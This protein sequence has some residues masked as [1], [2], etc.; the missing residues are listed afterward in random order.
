MVARVYFIGAGPAGVRWITQQ[1]WDILARVDVALVTDQAVPEGEWPWSAQAEHITADEVIS[2]LKHWTDQDRTVAV[3]VPESPAHHPLLPTW[4]TWVQERRQLGAVVPGIWRM[5]AVLDTEGFTLAKP[6][7]AVEPA[8]H[9][10]IATYTLS[11]DTTTWAYRAPGQWRQIGNDEMDFKAWL[12][13][14]TPASVAPSLWFSRR[15]LAGRTVMLLRAGRAAARA[16]ERL[17]EYGATVLLASVSAVT[18]PV[19]WEAVDEAITH[20]ERFDWVIFTS[21]E[22][23]SRFF[24]AMRRLRLDIRKL[25]AQI[26]VVGPQTA[27]AVQDYGIYPSLM[28]DEEYSQEGLAERLA[29]LPLLG[30]GILL[31]GGNLNRSYLK[32][33]LMQQG[34]LVTSIALYQNLLVPLS[35]AVA[36]RVAAHDIDAVFY[37]ASSAV[38]HLWE[39]H[40]ELREALRQTQAVSIGPLTTRTLHHY[41]VGEILEAETSSM[42]AMVETLV[43]HYQTHR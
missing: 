13:V 2:R 32:D 18:D 15:P 16:R 6:L 22:A 7:E 33:F 30:K 9:L 4:V 31:P 19:S 38:E 43:R 10:Q 39:P 20:L 5:T 37:T 35:P 3:L 21:Q 28:P 24:S 40:P 8:Q 17:E 14:K 29:S 34:A 23:V 27:A 12:T 36:K 26:A 42:E 1:G 25:S 11:A 41:V